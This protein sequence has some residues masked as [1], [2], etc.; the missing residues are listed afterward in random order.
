[1]ALPKKIKKTLP[2]VPPKEG[3]AR[4]EQL[5]EYINEDG[6]YLPKS[7]LHADLD[8]GMLDFVKNELEL[9][10]DGKKVPTVDIVITTQ[11][12]A[13]FQETWNFQDLNGNPVPPFVT[14]VRMPEVK[15]G[16]N[17][18]LQY[19]IPNRKEFFY[20]RVPTWDG[21]RKGMDIYKIPQPVPVD[22]TY[23]VKILCNRMRELNQFNKIIL[24]KFSSLQAYTFIKGHYVPI[25]LNDISDESVLDIE[26]RK[27][28]IQNYQFTMLGFLIDEE[29]FE[30]VPAISRALTMVE[31]ANKT[32]ARKAK[33]N[34]PRPNNF[35]FN[36]DFDDSTT[37][38]TQTFAYTADLLIQN[39]INVDSYSVYFNGD[40]VGDD[41]TTIQVS[42]GDV[43]TVDIIKNNDSEPAS[44]Q[45]E[46]YLV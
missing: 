35:G 16:T 13:Q 30:V 14:T 37:G 7:V 43:V 33:G 24:Q 6:T 15:Y 38:L 26:K 22:I 8:R 41:I 17:P 44:I 45:T 25:V 19:T 3:Y 18:S 2:L 10:V 4:R 34:P 11:N 42:T 46:A 21:Q 1:M 23:N 32:R 36:F 40:Y 39:R 5:L 9:V 27:F 28:Y 12:W 29:E 31:V 20:A